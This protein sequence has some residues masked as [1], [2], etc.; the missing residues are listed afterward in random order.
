VTVQ[1]A[2]PVTRFTLPPGSDATAPAERRGVPRDHVR[3]LVAR[4]GLVEHLRFHDLP[5]ILEPGDLVVVNTSATLPAAV[6]GRRGDGR[7]APVH[8]SAALDGGDWVVEVRRPDRHG[9]DLSVETGE[10]IGLPG[11]L[12]LRLSSP[13]PDP[14]TDVSRLWR[15]AVMPPTSLPAYLAQHGRPIQYGYHRKRFPLADYQTVF[16]TDAGSAEMPSAGRPFTASL[17]VRLVTRGVVLAPVTLHA[18]VSSPES[19]EPPTPERFEVPETTARLINDTHSAGGRVVAVGTTVVRAL[20]SV[21]AP[22][23]TVRPAAGW[24]DLVLGP[25]RPARAATGLVTGLHAPEASHLLLLEAVAGPPLVD[26]AY[27]AA[28][29]NRYLWHE[30]GD[31]TLFL[32]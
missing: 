20:E 5:G 2:T 21:A 26:L 11:R 24:T 13:Y 22:D 9:P 31:A 19:Y 8:V 15:A 14:S 1:A 29:D 30:F 4:P 3:L 12:D 23:G 25:D 10:T 28:V 17:V 7:R 27:Q 32:P 16:A 18:G 6:D